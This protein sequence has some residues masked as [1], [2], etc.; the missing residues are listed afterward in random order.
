M[1]KIKRDFII[2]IISFLIALISLTGCAH[3]NSNYP[4]VRVLANSDE[5]YDQ[6]MKL[7]VKE[8]LLN[9]LKELKSSN[10]D[11]T[12]VNAIQERLNSREFSYP[13]VV[14]YRD[15]TFPAKALNGEFLPSG[16]YPTLVVTIGAGEGTNWWSILYPEYFGISYEESDN[17][18]YRSYF[19]DNFINKFT[20]KL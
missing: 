12:V 5:V 8:E 7:T 6:Q 17:V 9:I 20:K 18:E 11:Q 14:A 3:P 16:T 13:I 1:K 2:V 19:Y 15:E 4:R 10:I